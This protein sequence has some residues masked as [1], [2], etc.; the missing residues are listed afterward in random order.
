M[1]GHL[2]MTT[3]R[4]ASASL[5]HSG[6]LGASSGPALDN[7]GDPAPARPRPPHQAVCVPGGTVTRLL[8]HTQAQAE[9]EQLRQWQQQQQLQSPRGDVPIADGRGEQR[10]LFP[11]SPSSSSSSVAVVAGQHE[12]KHGGGHVV[13]QQQLAESILNIDLTATDDAGSAGQGEEEAA[14]A[15]SPSPS[16]SGKRRRRGIGEMAQAAILGHYN[17]MVSGT[18][19]RHV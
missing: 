8:Q 7:K 5:Q 18:K 17:Q 10:R 13:Q 2:K 6:S 3:T 14:A 19:V 12:A 11:S 4:G 16:P 15:A 9:A 1:P